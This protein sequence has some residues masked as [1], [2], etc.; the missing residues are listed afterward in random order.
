MVVSIADTRTR[1]RKYFPGQFDEDFVSLLDLSDVNSG[2]LPVDYCVWMEVIQNGKKLPCEAFSVNFALSS[3]EIESEWT[4]P[5]A[6][7][8]VIF[9][10]YPAP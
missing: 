3:V 9:F 10:A 1:F 5:G 2:L 6:S 4:V 7:Y 8:E